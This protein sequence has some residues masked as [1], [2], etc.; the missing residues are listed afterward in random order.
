MRE[1]AWAA[2]K[3]EAPLKVMG[4]LVPSSPKSALLWN[5]D[6]RE[7]EIAMAESRI[8]NLCGRWAPEA[9]VKVGVGPPA[10][11][12]HRAIRLHGA[13]LMVAGGLRE[14]LLAAE[15]A[16]PV[17]YVGPARRLKAERPAEFAI[18]RGAA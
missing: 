12:Y 7:F 18:A 15:S 9:A 11:V 13:G 16:C 10:A 4:A 1:A 3:M 8:Q 14:N 17:L 5:R 2:A 6:E